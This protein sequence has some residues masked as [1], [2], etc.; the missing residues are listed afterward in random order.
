MSRGSEKKGTKHRTFAMHV[1]GPNMTRNHAMHTSLPVVCLR[2]K[3][4]LELAVI[5]RE[6]FMEQT[7][8]IHRPDSPLP[9]T[10]GRAVAWVENLNNTAIMVRVDGRD[11]LLL[12]T[13]ELV[14]ELGV[15]GI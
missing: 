4:D 5:V 9:N 15:R 3:D 6:A 11:E 1:H 10:G 2:P 14:R 8:F 12:L 7:A 13:D